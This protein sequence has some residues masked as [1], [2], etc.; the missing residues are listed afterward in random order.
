MD[1]TYNAKIAAVKLNYLSGSTLK[2][3]WEEF[4]K[5]QLLPRVF[6]LWSGRLLWTICITWR[7][8]RITVWRALS[9]FVENHWVIV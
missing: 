9:Y 6:G 3:G 8:L 2:G 1:W 4:V 7:G 5:M